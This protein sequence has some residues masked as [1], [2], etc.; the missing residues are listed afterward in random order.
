MSYQFSEAER[1][2]I[3][4]SLAASTGIVATASGYSLVPGADVNCVPVYEALLSIIDTKLKDVGDYDAATIKD[5]RN[6]KSWLSVAVGANGGE[7]FY[8]E[9]IRSFTGRQGQLRLGREFTAEEMQAASNVVARN[10]VNGLLSGDQAHGLNAWT[11]PSI[12]QI[13]ALDA[14]AIGQTLFASTLD[15]T[16]TAVTNNAAWSGTLGFSLLGGQKPFETWRLIASG[17]SNE[18]GY[19]DAQANTLDDIKN[20]LFAADS[21]YT[22][23]LSVIE[24]FEY[25]YLFDHLQ[26]APDIYNWAKAQSEIIS[27][28]G[29]VSLFVRALV[30]DTPS[31]PMMNFILDNG[32]SNVL[33]MLQSSYDGKYT[34]PVSGS[35]Y[36][37]SV[38]SFFSQISSL[39]QQSTKIKLLSDFGGYTSLVDTAAQSTLD[40]EAVRNSLKF[41]S[42]IVVYRDDGF[43]GRDLDLYDPK[44][45]SGTVTSQWLVDRAEMLTRLGSITAGSYAN[46]SIQQF[47]YTDMASGLQAVMHTGT[48]NPL[49]FFADDGGAKFE[50]GGASDHL[51]GG[52]GDDTITGSDGDDY[53]EGGGG[54]DILD[55]GENNDLLFG[56]AGDDELEGGTGNDTLDGGL[57]NDKYTFHT[58]D[59][60]DLIVDKDG[61]GEVIVNGIRLSG[62]KQIAPSTN[63]WYVEDGD[64][65]IY[66]TFTESMPNYPSGKGAMLITYGTSDSIVINDYDLHSSLLGLQNYQSPAILSPT[67]GNKISGDDDPNNLVG[68]AG[69]DEISGYGQDDV[70]GPD[71]SKGGNDT[72]YGGDGNDDIYGGNGDDILSGGNGK[73]QVLGGGGNDRLYAGD[74][75]KIDDAINEENYDESDGEGAFLD[76]QKGDDTIIGSVG[77]DILLGGDGKDLLIGGAGNDVLYADYDGEVDHQQNGDSWSFSRYVTTD[78]SG[79]KEH[80]VRLDTGGYISPSWEVGQNDTIVAGSGEDWASGGDGD[81]YIDGGSDNDVLWGDAGNDT[82]LGGDGDDIIIGDEYPLY[83]TLATVTYGSDYLDGGAGNDSIVGDNGNDVITG[84]AGNDSLWGDGSHSGLEGD[85]NDYLDG[86]DGDDLITGGRGD[87]IIYG[88]QGADKIFGDDDRGI[89]GRDYI[90]GE[91]G[92]DSIYGGYENDTILG[93]DDDD[94]INGD[95][96]VITAKDGD[97][98]LDGGSGNDILN[99]NGGDD[100][101]IGGDGND[102]LNGDS[103]IVQFSGGAD[104]LDGGAGDDLL[105]GGAGNDTLIGGSGADTLFDYNGENTFEGGGG[106]DTLYG[107]GQADTYIFSRGDGNDL[108]FDS[109]GQNLVDLSNA[110]SLEGVV[111]ERIAGAG[112]SALRVKS[113]SDSVEFS[114]GAWANSTF[115]FFGG[116]EVTYSQLLQLAA[117]SAIAPAYAPGLS[118][119]GNELSNNI[120]GQYGDDILNGVGGD[121]LLQGGAGDDAYLISKND[122]NDYIVDS[123]GVDTVKFGDG[124]SKESLSLS[125]R[126]TNTGDNYL[127]V[128]YGTGSIAISDG[129]YGSIDAFEFADGTK[130]NY[131]DALLLIDGLVLS[132]KPGVIDLFG[133]G[134]NDTLLGSSAGDHILGQSGDDSIDGGL[135]NDSLYGAS[136]N[137]T[138]QGGAGNDLLYG[139]DGDDILLGGAG[140]DIIDAGAGNNVVQLSWNSGH[141]TVI[142]SLGANYKI[143]LG[144]GFDTN[145]LWTQRSGDDL[146]LSIAD[147]GGSLVLQEYFSNPE[148]WTVASASG[149]FGVQQI[150]ASQPAMQQVTLNALQH[151]FEKN[152]EVA[153]GD[154]SAGERD[155]Q[156]GSDGKYWHT[157]S[158]TQGSN[159]YKTNYIY[160]M[161]FSYSSASGSYLTVGGEVNWTYTHSSE[162]VARTKFLQPGSSSPFS[163]IKPLFL[164]AGSSE[165]QNLLQTDYGFLY[166]FSDLSNGPVFIPIENS[167]ALLDPEARQTSYVFYPV[168]SLQADPDNGTSTGVIYTTNVLQYYSYKV[169]TGSDTASYVTVANGN[170]FYGG[171]GNDTISGTPEQYYLTETGSVGSMLSGGDGDDVITGSYGDDIIVGGAGNDTLN[172]SAGKDIYAYLGEEGVDV[173]NDT[174]RR[175]MLSNKNPSGGIG[176][177]FGYLTGDQDFEDTVILPSG[178]TLQNASFSWGQLMA[179]GDYSEDVKFSSNLYMSRAFMVYTTLDITLL[180]GE[181]IRVVMPHP[182][183]A[184][185]N[186]IEYF[187]FSDGTKMSMADVISHYNLGNTPDLFN[188]GSLLV[189]DSRTI[190]LAGGDGDDTIIGSA[191]VT[192]WGVYGENLMGGNGNDSIVGGDGGDIIVGGKGSDTMLGGAGDDVIGNR[193]EE[194]YGDSNF[195]KG[196]K[197]NDTIYGSI[198]ADTYLFEL[199]DGQDVVTDLA[200]QPVYGYNQQI[201]DAAYGGSIYTDWAGM[202]EDLAKGFRDAWANVIDAISDTAVALGRGDNLRFGDGISAPD[203]DFAYDGADLLLSI[204]DTTDE[205]RF[206]NWLKFKD[207][208]LASISFSDG[209]VWNS[210]DI[211]QRLPSLPS[212]IGLTNAITLDANTKILQG[213]S[214]SDVL[215]GQASA[216]YIYGMDGDDTLIGGIGDDTLAGGE[217]ADTYIF[218]SGAGNDHIKTGDTGAAVDTLVLSN[219]WNHEGLWFSQEGNDLKIGLSDDKG[220]VT[221][222]DWYT[223]SGN[224]LKQI[225]AGDGAVLLDGQVQA[226]VDAMA[227]FAAS[228]PTIDQYFGP[229]RQALNAVIAASW[230]SS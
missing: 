31:A 62:A 52:K 2:T 15:P 152:V 29:D 124:I 214:A 144:A 126:Y 5:L 210:D 205:I 146:I 16:D 104:Y 21:Y 183:D 180:S 148:G 143:V 17:D 80:T 164:P 49:A 9:L 217:G 175:T 74:I 97:D 107:G 178:T 11:V 28:N 120:L 197:G 113:G 224:H 229:E 25:E 78:P 42:Q 58:G 208:P 94:T 189:G 142:N 133:S 226:L 227:T 161:G 221:I 198:H 139:G 167:S 123:A 89:D 8:S 53:L 61:L 116:V 99:G 59:G 135:G 24:K 122:G 64:S 200:H 46:G 166:T 201:F 82:V 54:S 215:I 1:E 50:G 34:A 179:E 187:Q 170:I 140:D 194:Y 209:T 44:T 222:H 206:T 55:G 111:I 66:L 3:M 127:V 14:Q 86:A 47:S 96:D 159:L 85:D 137:D 18:K 220:S 163:N 203:V 26:L 68:T 121:D 162:I 102:T 39:E 204:K 98:Y 147:G 72:L 37:S 199:G 106:N 101:L 188:S 181:V 76:G 128:N 75:I 177:G 158:N 19:A 10:V 132:A 77:N 125:Y 108:A 69:D 40:G 156:L 109:G 71:A 154:Y 70:I 100:I 185:S 176:G 151:R 212:D 65:K 196:G 130:L 92:A 157:T 22:S 211:D 41:L 145:D 90:D 195:Y 186:G 56:M 48:G 169:V 119:V 149:E 131:Q 129:A 228:P 63:S 168:E 193:F 118:L 88:G 171:A 38:Y 60:A 219:W 191:E 20:L 57:G 218:S 81:D 153:F 115:V 95:M 105:Q 174:A 67:A 13:A 173:I 6:A 155:A 12:S 202:P 114:G 207:R 35:D 45:G 184:A 87:D 33:A 190:T 112:Y 165:L 216:D 4:A 192:D 150:I 182:D 172:G 230:Q 103:F 117:L 23:F 225:T 73:D 27:N 36:T 160:D 141:D 93:G 51:Y 79:L 134:G 30:K 91:E 138:L 32:Y 43:S 84:G 223:A 110:Y 136:G 7:G 213:T 83:P